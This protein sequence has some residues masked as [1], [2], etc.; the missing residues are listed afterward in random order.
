MAENEREKVCHD[1]RWF[2]VQETLDAI[3][4]NN[5][6]AA[7][8]DSDDDFDGEWCNDDGSLNLHGGDVGCVSDIQTLLQRATGAAP[9]DDNAV[10][11]PSA[12]VTQPT[13]TSITSIS[14]SESIVSTENE[15]VTEDSDSDFV[16]VGTVTNTRR[17]RGRGAS[18]RGAVSARGRG[19]R[20]RGVCRGVARGRVRNTT[21]STQNEEWLCGKDFTPT[22]KTFDQHTGV[23]QNVNTDNFKEVDF[24]GLFI[25]DDIFQY[26]VDQTNLYA[27]QFMEDHAD[28]LASKPHARA[29]KWKRTNINEMKVFFG[30]IILMGLEKRPEISLYW[31]TDRLFF[32]PVYGQTMARDRFLLLLKFL[33]FND[34]SKMPQPG[35][36]DYDRLYKI[37]PLLTKLQERFEDVYKPKREVAVD[38]SLLLWKGRLG[39]RQYMP[40]KR[41]RF[42]IKLFLVCDSTGYTYRFRV[43]QGKEDPITSMAIN[44]PPDSQHLSMTEKVVVWLMGDLLGKGYICYA[45][46]FYSSIPLNK[47]L[48]SKDTLHCGT[49]RKN[50]VPQCV[51]QLPVPA[52]DCDSLYHEQTHVVKFMDSKEVYLVTSLHDST[53]K[54]KKRGRTQAVFNQPQ[55]SIDY[56]Y[57]MGGVD[58]QDQLIEPYDITRKTQKWTKKLAFHFLQVAT[59]NAHI[60]AR[61]RGYKGDYL[62]YL[63][64]IVD[65]LL[66]RLPEPTPEPVP[67]PPP[68]QPTHTMGTASNVDDDVRLHPKAHYPVPVPPT[69]TKQKPYRKCRVC[70]AKGLRTDVRYMCTQCPS[71]PALCIDNN[72]FRVYHTKQDYWI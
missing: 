19:V 5:E 10:A 16:P 6:I 59:L 62:A 60:V 8:A 29:K 53:T 67:P 37:R 55:A 1:R 43:Y 35:A 24:M 21:V 39:F 32:T 9:P 36:Q 18:R 4:S 25:T 14:E 46:N 52:R 56:N 27:N 50:R 41:A 34:N 57:Y 72:C 31:S 33:H 2:S 13:Q 65:T 47:Y 12:A 30:L 28:Y 49:V 15:N 38:E 68:D 7:D 71:Q 3:H 26:F 70:T 61:E 64:G 66:R 40:L 22:Q 23:N 51:Q 17:G 54:R 69:D 58:T 42:G 48:L 63:R 20:G 11:G 44:L 45:D